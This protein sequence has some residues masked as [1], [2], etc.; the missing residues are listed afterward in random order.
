MFGRV[1]LGRLKKE[2]ERENEEVELFGGCLVGGE[3]GE[4]MVGPW[5]FLPRPTK[6]FSPKNGEK[7]GRGSLIIK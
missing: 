3:E 5:C 7:M 4:M 2:R 1:I 6:K